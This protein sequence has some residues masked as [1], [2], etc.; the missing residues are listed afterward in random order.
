MGAGVEHAAVPLPGE[1]GSGYRAIRK[2]AERD[3]L[4]RRLVEYNRDDLQ[5]LGAC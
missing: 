3:E 2:P 5:A 1:G 4:R